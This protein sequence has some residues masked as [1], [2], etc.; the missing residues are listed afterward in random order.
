MSPSGTL[1]NR[2]LY[3]DTVIP[4]PFVPCSNIN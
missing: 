1:A 2:S 4:F 3:F